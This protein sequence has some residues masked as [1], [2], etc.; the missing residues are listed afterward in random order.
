ME[1]SK[2]Y[3]SLVW[4]YFW[5]QK[6]EE[7]IDIFWAASHIGLI[8]LIIVISTLYPKLGLIILVAII[9]GVILIKLASW[10]QSNFEKAESRAKATLKKRRSKV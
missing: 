10:I 7:I 5:Q 4:K 1:D 2:A 8:F 6:K 3:K 9:I